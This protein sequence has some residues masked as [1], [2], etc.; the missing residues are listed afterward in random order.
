MM[1][2]LGLERLLADKKLTSRLKKKRLALLGHPASLNRD[3]LHSL[4]A[5][6]K[7]SGLNFTCA[8]G[9]QHGMLGDKQDNMIESDDYRDPELGIPVYSL[10]STSR[11]PTDSMM[12]N[13]DTVLIDLQDVGCRIY[14]YLTTLR[15]ML[16]AAAKHKKEVWVLDRPNPIGRPVEGFAC[17]LNA[18]ESFVGASTLPMRH[19]LT[20]GELALWLCAEFKLK[21]ELRVIP[22]KNYSPN[23]SPD[24]G[25]PLK[26]LAWI[27]PSPNVPTLDTARCYPGTVLLEG[28]MLSEGRG[29]TRPLQIFGAPKMQSEALI[30]L[31]EKRAP[32][33]LKGCRLRPCF[34][35]PTF[36][37]YK[38]ELCSGVQIHVDPIFYRHKDFKPYRLMLLLFKCFR[39]LHP[40]FDLWRKPPYEYETER[41]PIDLLNGTPFARNWVDDPAARPG[42]LEKALLRDEKEWL[43]KRRPHLLYS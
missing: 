21:V 24:F 10:Y 6:Q 23:A 40:D 42:D 33:W 19:G 8:F 28:T 25:W 12:Q 36:H 16:E 37:K 30:T 27:N 22:M 32:Q 38:G 2:S 41:L 1:T 9:P 39:E 4:R 11:R 3:L 17:D 20:M 5:L 14:T 43:A 29:T 31:M 34:F 7:I 26:K 35:E 18:F 13:F 15:Y